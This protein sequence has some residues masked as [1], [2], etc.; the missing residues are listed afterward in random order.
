MML[1]N[2]MHLQEELARWNSADGP[3]RRFDVLTTSLIADLLPLTAMTAA[4]RAA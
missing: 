4:G 2:N 3:G 1:M